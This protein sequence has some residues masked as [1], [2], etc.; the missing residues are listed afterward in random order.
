MMRCNRVSL[1]SGAL[2]GKMGEIVRCLTKKAREAMNTKSTTPLEDF[3]FGRELQ[4][5][6][7]RFRRLGDENLQK[8]GITISQLRVIA[9]ISCH[10]EETVYQKTLEEHF[11]IRRSSVTG[12]LQNME[13]S[14]LLK[15]TGSSKDARAKIV[16]LTEKGRELDEKLRNYIQGVES[17][18]MKGFE[19]EEKELLRGF[20]LRMLENLDSVERSR[21]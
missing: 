4:N 17:E 1:T 12:L 18:L 21:L 6:A 16:S 20:L 14:G 5:V 13:K 10:G 3:R 2:Y 11:E 9:Y 15:R 7:N 8:E 19:K